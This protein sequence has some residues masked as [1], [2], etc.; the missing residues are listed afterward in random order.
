M[1]S[2]SRDQPVLGGGG[3]WSGVP[4]ENHRIAAS[5]QLP[6]HMPQPGLK[7]LTLAVVR[8]G[9]QSV[10]HLRRL[11]FQNRP[12]ENIDPKRYQYIIQIWH[13]CG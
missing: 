1:L 3:N 10:Q 2:R 5:H 4:G 12:S 6:S 9:E 13:L 8:D 11:G 7:R